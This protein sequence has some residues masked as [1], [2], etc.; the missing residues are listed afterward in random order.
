MTITGASINHE[1]IQE[2][3]PAIVIVEEA[4]EVLEADLL[5]ALTPGLQHLVLIGDQK[6]LRPKVCTYKLRKDYYFDLSMMER[7]LRNDFPYKTLQLQNRMWPE[8]SELLWDIYPDLQDNLGR[9]I[10]HQPAEC[11]VKSMVFWNHDATEKGGRSF[12]NREEARRAILQAEFLLT[13]GVEAS[14]ITILAA[15]Q[16]QVTEIRNVM[17]SCGEPGM[18]IKQADNKVQLS[19][20]D[21][22]QGDENDFVIVSLV[23]CNKNGAIGFLAEESRRCVAQSRARCGM[24]LL[25]SGATLAHRAHSSW[26]PLL[27][28][29]RDGGWVCD[30]LQVQCPKHR[31]KSTANILDADAL[32]KLMGQPG[33]L[34][35]LPCGKLYSCGLHRCSKSCMTEHDHA[36]FMTMHQ[37]P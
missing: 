10:L 8:F 34:C 26:A 1:L 22:F 37:A 13:S 12:T 16:G 17:R 28:K 9:V 18:L 35:A 11:L 23:R 32:E 6:Q 15:Y 20:G 19:T 21:M 27:T 36:F 24:Y 4:A 30:E 14:R 31:E 25:G 3:A 29:M 5:A 33:K 2:L 7:L